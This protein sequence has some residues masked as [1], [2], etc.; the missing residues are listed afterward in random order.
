MSYTK[1]AA[2]TTAGSEQPALIT[3]SQDKTKVFDLVSMHS[4][5]MTKSIKNEKGEVI[6]EDYAI[7]ADEKNP[8]EAI[9]KSVMSIVYDAF[10]KHTDGINSSYQITATAIVVK[11]N[12]HAA[13][14]KNDLD[15]VDMAI[16]DAIVYGCLN[17]WF[18]MR[19]Q[20]E[21][22]KFTNDKLY[23]SIELLK[24]RMFSLK[25]RRAFLTTLNNA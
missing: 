4:S 22:T 13:Y 12:D 9:L 14:N 25:I 19:A 2:V 8:F 5:F 10:K 20:G 21:L 11:V 24:K 6:G 7:S 23:E 16:E 18:T 3:F 1:T 15:L 17:G